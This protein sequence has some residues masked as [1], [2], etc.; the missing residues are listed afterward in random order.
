MKRYLF[1]IVL[2]LICILPSFV[3]ADDLGKINGDFVTIRTS[4]GGSKIKSLLYGTELNVIGT[5]TYKNEK[6]YKVIYD[7]VNTGYVSATYVWLYKDITKDDKEYCKTLTDLGF[8]ESYCP[9]LSYI[10]CL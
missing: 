8:H 9:F 5:E 2:V 7:G 3:F 4:P 10:H 6:Y 1:L